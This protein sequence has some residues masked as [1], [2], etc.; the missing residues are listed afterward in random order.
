[1]KKQVEGTYFLTAHVESHQT[2]K[3]SQDGTRERSVALG[4]EDADISARI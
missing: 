4:I 2:Q 1:M 3:Q